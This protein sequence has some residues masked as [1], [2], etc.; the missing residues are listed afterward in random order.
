[1]FIVAE[2]GVNHNGDPAIAERLIKAA[3][4]VGADAVKL[5]TFKAE[6]LA[7]K[8]ASKDR[9]MKAETG[10]GGTMYEMF[11]RLELPK[12]SYPA[13]KSMAES[14][15]LVFFSSPFDED[16]ADFLFGIGVK[17]FKI[18]S[19]EITNLP[20]LK[21]IGS[22]GLPVIL[23]TGMSTLEE[24]RMAVKTLLDAGCKEIILLHATISHPAKKEDLNLRAI[25]A[26]KKEFEFPVGYSDHTDDI[27]VPSL[28]AASGAVL[29]EKHFT[30]DKTMNGP[31][32]S[33]SMNPIEMG[34]MVK[35]IRDTEIIL[36]F[37]DKIYVKNEEDVRVLAR[38]SVVVRGDISRGTK[39]EPSMITTKRPGTGIQPKDI[40][41]VSGRLALVDIAADEVIKWDMISSR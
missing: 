38:R 28:A 18:A 34:E 8:G 9:Y 11:K 36:G 40:D 16:A 20:L 39:I 30:L 3:A 31:D 1:V 27:L 35:M 10:S 17:V 7:V 19:A 14:M 2:I 41:A 21:Y 12:E 6:D 26:L 15:G 5:Q 22:K 37:A 24:V 13:L 4:N 32:H 23:S 33:H 25:G 29:I